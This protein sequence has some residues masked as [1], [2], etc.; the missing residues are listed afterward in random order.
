MFDPQARL[1][2]LI[3]KLR[4]RNCRIT[5]QRMAV[6]ET[7]VQGEEHPSV[8]QVYEQVK[9]DLP[10]TSLATIYK[11]LSLLKEMGEVLEL[12][13]SDGSSRYDCK[14]PYPH[15]HLICVRCGQ[16]ADLEVDVVSKL[17]SEATRTASFQVLSHRLDLIGVCLQCQQA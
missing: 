15:P 2:G 1:T 7:L 8:R 9:A 16:I 12:S 10:T 11:T 3:G 17:S 13:F 6:L 14:R 4:D 5:P